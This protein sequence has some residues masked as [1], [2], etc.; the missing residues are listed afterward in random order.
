[1]PKQLLI[2]FAIDVSDNYWEDSNLNSIVR[3]LYDQFSQALTAA[4]IT[5]EESIKPTTKRPPKPKLES[6]STPTVAPPAVGDQGPQTTGQGYR[7]PQDIITGVAAP[8][9]AA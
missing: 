6:A 9:V 7:G 3:P 5:F 8:P 1:M 4:G 2:T